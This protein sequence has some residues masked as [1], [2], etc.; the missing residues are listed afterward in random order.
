MGR[1]FKKGD[2]VRVTVQSRL[3]GY[4]LGDA[5]EVLTGSE[6]LPRDRRRYY[7]VMMYKGGHLCPTVFAEDEIEPEV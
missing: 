2:R 6:F 4:E 5:E 1:E 7:L 3:N